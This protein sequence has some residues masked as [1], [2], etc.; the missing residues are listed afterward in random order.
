MIPLFL[1]LLLI[2][3]CL[4]TPAFILI[5]LSAWRYTHPQPV[6]PKALKT[7]L[8]HQETLMARGVVIAFIGYIFIIAGFIKAVM[9]IIP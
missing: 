7:Y 4:Q 2:G 5:I 3:V 8:K 1:I 9:V 6:K